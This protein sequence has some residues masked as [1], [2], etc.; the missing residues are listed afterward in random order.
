MNFCVIKTVQNYLVF[1]F[2]RF[3]TQVFFILLCIMMLAC[4]VSFILLNHLGVARK[5]YATVQTTVDENACYY[6]S[7]EM[8]LSNESSVGDGAVVAKEVRRGSCRSRK[9][10]ATLQKTAENAQGSTPEN[11]VGLTRK[12]YVYLLIIIAFINALS[13]GVL[14]AVSSYSSLPYGPNTYHLAA[15]LG[16]MANPVACL[17]AVFLPMHS[18]FGIGVFTV[19]S[20]GRLII[21]VFFFFF[22]TSVQFRLH[23][24]FFSD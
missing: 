18:F 11:I 4:S 21:Y 19:I 7:V 5:F 22:V 23:S 13:N 6:N 3:S 1:S 24:C 17:I 20:T 16:N 15:T 10:S 2:D 8:Q 9:N 14:P 12:D